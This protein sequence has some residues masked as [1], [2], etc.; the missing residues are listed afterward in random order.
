ML[1]IKFI[2]ENPEKFKKGLKK[3][4]VDFDVAYLLEVDEKRR[5]KIKE[6]DDLRHRHKEHSDAIAKASGNERVEMIEKVKMEKQK[7]EYTAFE[8]RT[9]EDEF[10]EL[11]YKIPNL[12]LEDVPEGKDERENVVMREVGEKLEFGFAPRDYFAIAKDLGLIDTERAAKVSGSRFGYIKGDLARLE[13]ALVHFAFERLM[14][15]GFMPIVPPVIIKEEM[16][17]KL[18]YVDTEKDKAERYF[19][20]EDKMYFV[21]T[22]EQSLVPMH[23]DEI[24]DEKNMPMRYAGFSTCFRREAGSYGKDTQGILRVHQFDKVEMVIFASSNT[25]RAEHERMIAIEEEL[26]QALGIPYRVVALC[27]GDTAK[28]SARTVDIEA[29]LP[30]QNNGKGEYRET[31]SSSNTTDFQARRLNIKL[32]RTDGK[33]EC[34]HIL[35]GTAFAIGRMIIA[36]LENYQQEDGSIKIPEVLQK[37]MGGMEIIS[38]D[39]KI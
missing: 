4:L 8:L 3:K 19:L 39:K 31:H 24:L 21:G 10:Q 18:G 23:A 33:L 14:A 12:P 26:M 17:Q 30:G 13:F 35:N 22:A 16:M 5:L 1:D 28:P 7:L 25:A 27:T 11:M 20:P 29:W 32:R 37:Y 38:A 36:I 34:A 6:V 15:H 9:I 2:R